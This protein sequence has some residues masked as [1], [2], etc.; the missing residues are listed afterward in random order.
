[1]SQIT[2]DFARTMLGNAQRKEHSPLTVWEEEQLARAWLELQEVKQSHA[3]A[4]AKMT[5]VVK[6]I[7]DGA[8]TIEELNAELDAITPVAAVAADQQEAGKS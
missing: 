4:W 1:M 3:N 6:T 2:E 8:L 5:A 7:N